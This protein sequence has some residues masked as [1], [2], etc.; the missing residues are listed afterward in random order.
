MK[1]QPWYY[2]ELCLVFKKSNVNLC[3]INTEYMLWGITE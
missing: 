2:E 3:I 1:Y